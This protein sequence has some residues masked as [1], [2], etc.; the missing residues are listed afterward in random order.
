MEYDN[1]VILTFQDDFTKFSEAV[2]L[3]NSEVHTVAEAFVTHIICQ[4][5]IPEVVLSDQGSNF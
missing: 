3:P 5:G 1:K 2:T 4:H